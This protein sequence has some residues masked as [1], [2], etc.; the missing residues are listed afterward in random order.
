MPGMRVCSGL[1][2]IAGLALSLSAGEARPAGSEAGL[3][4]LQKVLDRYLEAL[5]GR[6]ALE[7]VQTRYVQGEAEMSLMP[8][9]VSKWE[10]ITKAPNKRLSIFTVP[11]FGQ[12]TDGF[13]G[14]TAW[15]RNGDGPVTERV[16]DEFAK[17]RRD[18]VFNRELQMTKVYPDLALKRVEKVGAE[19]AYVAE[20]RPAP[21]NVER[22]FFG[23]KSG[24]LLRQESEFGP[25]AGRVRAS[26]LFE[27]YRKVDKL[28]LPH[29]L[30]IHMSGPGGEMDTTVRFTE[31]KHNVPVDDSRFAR[32]KE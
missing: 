17:T 23:Q 29:R 15:V 5:G 13:D 27:D 8:G 22:F 14:T 31:V 32:P 6:S 2:A 3:P 19:A 4:P 10:L 16:G 24:Y 30:R 26:V 1:A 12:V 9:V 18:A 11:D 7:R 28:L 20:S 25:E 21:D